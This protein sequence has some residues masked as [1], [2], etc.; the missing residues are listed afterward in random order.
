MPG[1]FGGGGGGD[2]A[3]QA[4]QIQAAG[5]ERAAQLQYQMY[6]DAVA[7]LQPWLKAGGASVE[8]LGGLY[9][10][11]GY[12][13][14]DPTQTLQATPGYNWL[15]GQGAQAR[16]LAAASKGLNLSGAQQRGLTSF[17]QN[18]ALTNAWNPYISGLQNLSGTG[19]G[20]AGTAGGWGMKAGENMGQDYLLAAQAQAQ[21]LYNQ[22]LA[23]QM[24]GTNWG[25][26][27]GLGLGIGLAP[28]TGTSLIGAGIKGLGSL[29]SGAAPAYEGVTSD[30]GTYGK[31][32]SQFAGSF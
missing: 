5:S 4:A 16:E 26:L 24:G 32:M 1:L 3:V 8:Q 21:G 10:L 30:L 28:F 2:A 14:V 23:E 12:T 11:P 19:V 15:L 20:A 9:N 18:L 22:Q 27:L 29:F 25:N 13:K 7:R 17:G 6:Q 31:L